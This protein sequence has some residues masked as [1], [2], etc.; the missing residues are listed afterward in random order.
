MGGMST[1]TKDYLQE[2]SQQL[3]CEAQELFDN[4]GDVASQE[5]L[6]AREELAAGVAALESERLEDMHMERFHNTP[7]ALFREIAEAVL[8]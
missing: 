6:H 1:G 4:V 7:W 2:W 8:D 5:V 3:C